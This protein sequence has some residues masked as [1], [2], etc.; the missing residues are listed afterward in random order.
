MPLPLPNTST[1]SPIIPR[2]CLP[3]VLPAHRQCTHQPAC[4]YEWW[5]ACL[6]RHLPTESPSCPNMKVWS[7]SANRAAASTA[8]D[9]PALLLV[10]LAIAAAAIDPT[11]GACTGTYGWTVCAADISC[12]VECWCRGAVTPAQEVRRAVLSAAPHASSPNLPESPV[13]DRVWTGARAAVRA[14]QAKEV[15]AGGLTRGVC[16][17]A[18]PGRL[19]PKLARPPPW[20]ALP[21]A[22]GFASRYAR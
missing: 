9:G 1:A 7:C 6:L 20:G 16:A 14:G 15:L 5:R 12:S 8:A 18:G 21:R 4:C 10:L 17:W 11:C 2:H 22:G 3:G 13:G 19:L